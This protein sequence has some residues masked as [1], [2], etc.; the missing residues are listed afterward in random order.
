M[1]TVRA[2]HQ[3]LE[4]IGRLNDAEIDLASA[5]LALAVLDHP[6]VDQDAYR[7]HLAALAADVGRRNAARDGALRDILIGQ[8]G[9]RGD[10]E[11]YDDLA[12]RQPDPGDR[13]PARLAGGAVDPVAPCRACPG[14]A[15]RRP[16][17]P[18]RTS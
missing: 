2:V 17:L 14:L 16:E 9:Y 6:H 8:Y 18:R 5:A 13:P 11:S 7:S 10:R 12:Q 15:R 1:D 3:T 4:Q